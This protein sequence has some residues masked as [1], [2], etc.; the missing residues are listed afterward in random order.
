MINLW[1]RIYKNLILPFKNKKKLYP[2]VSD[3]VVFANYFKGYKNLLIIDPGYGF[4]VILSR[5]NKIYYK[6]GSKINLEQKNRY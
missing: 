1:K 4:H 2:P 3:K 6:I 5:L